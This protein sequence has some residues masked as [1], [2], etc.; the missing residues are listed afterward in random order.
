MGPCGAMDCTTGGGKSLTRTNLL[1][2]TA[3]AYA[4]FGWPVLPLTWITPEG[5]CSCG[6]PNDEKN[7]K[8]GKHPLTETGFHDATTD[9]EQIR[10]WWQRWPQANIGVRTGKESGLVVL[11]VDSYKGGD[12]TIKKY[13]VPETLRAKTGGGGWHH[14]Y[15]YPDVGVVGCTVE[16]LGPGLDTKADGGYVVAPPSNHLQGEYR[17]TPL[18][19]APD[20]DV[21]KSQMAPCPPWILALSHRGAKGTA[22]AQAT[23]GNAHPIAQAC[24]PLLSQSRCDSYGDWLQVGMIC[25]TAGLPCTAWDEWSKKSPKYTAGACEEKWDSF[26]AARENGVTVGTLVFWAAQDQGLTT[27]ELMARIAPSYHLTDAGNAERFAMEHAHHLRYVPEWQRWIAFDGRRWRSGTGDAVAVQLAIAMFRSM[28]AQAA[29]AADSDNRERLAKWSLRCEAAARVQAMLSIAHNLP[30]FI[31]PAQELDADPYLLNCGNGTIDLRSGTLR[32]HNPSDMLTKISPVEYDPEARSQVWEDHLRRVTAGD[33][34]LA[35]FIQLAAGY[36]ATGDV[37]EEVLFLVHGPTAGGKTTTIEALKTALG[38]Y[39]QTTDFET[40]LKRNQIGGIRNDIAR[41]AGARLVV[42]VEVDEGKHLAEGLVK[43]LTGGD[44][45]TARFLHQEFFEFKPQCKLWLVCNDAPRANDTDDAL[46]RRIIRVPF[47]HTI[48]KHE[49][50][51]KVK[52]TL[53]DPA[54]GGP[55]VLAWIVEGCAKWR[56]TG[57]IVPLAIEQATEEYRRSQDPLREFFDDWCVFEPH[58]YVRVTTLRNAYEAYAQETGIKYP[59]GP[60]EFNKRLEARE[61]QRVLRGCPNDRG[62]IKATKCWLGVR[63]KTVDDNSP[64]STAS[65]TE[66]GQSGEY[67]PI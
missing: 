20:P 5:R 66:D 54:L 15:R 30:A 17:F 47:E 6:R 48:P 11:D 13:D 60:K 8:P 34:D 41:L 9:A 59:L 23:D 4:G 32:P 43:M 55:A 58:E 49:R 57:L 24:L 31:T 56:T 19:P 18:G 25:K 1:I 36:S 65:G 12:E 40:F 63:L 28:L 7:H 52:A 46:W 64:V 51:P 26:T 38:D 27:S 61:C 62:T 37:S 67:L 29:K 33:K 42:S 16:K 39:G 50:D 3:L 35:E 21:R 45:I 14:F 10:R 53:K 2:E 22:P 44:T